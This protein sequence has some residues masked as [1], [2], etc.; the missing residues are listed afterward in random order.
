M[1]PR[2]ASTTASSARSARRR[3]FAEVDLHAMNLTI[4]AGALFRETIYDLADRH[5]D[6]ADR[7]PLVA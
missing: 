7:D 2:G 3:L 5:P 6:W 1:E 4:D